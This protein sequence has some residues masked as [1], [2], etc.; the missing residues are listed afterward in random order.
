[1]KKYYKE[2]LAF[3]HDTGHSE[4]ALQS[5]PGILDI[6]GRN[7][8]SE[9]LVIDL[10]CGSGLWAQ[11]LLKANYD[12]IGVDISEAMISI[13][14]KRAPKAEFL[15]GSLFKAEIP[16]C[17]AVTSLGECLN[18]L[19]DSD[20]NDKRLTSLF[21]RIYRA[22]TPGGVFIF[23]IAEPG[24]IKLGT[25]TRSFSERE[26]WMV[27]VEKKEDWER[28]ILTRRIISFRKVGRH[29]RRD[30]ETHRLRLFK[31]SDL[32]AELRRT[33]FSVR[34]ARSYG[35]YRLP[36]AHVAFI[37]RKPV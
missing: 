18:Y 28:N 6:L 23:D 5:A 17:R 31:A 13:A 25:V 21:R 32:T 24:Q 33:G 1:M 2:D 26:D 12:V 8:I 29:Y 15:V 10:G 36:E 3:I 4:F 9:G 34:T 27:A 14:R 19:F 30:E 16:S 37:A 22:L 7:K 11:E 35:L 20:N